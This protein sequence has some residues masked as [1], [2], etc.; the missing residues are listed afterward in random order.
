MRVRVEFRILFEIFQFLCRIYQVFNANFIVS[1]YRV[2]VSVVNAKSRLI[3]VE[4]SNLELHVASV[5]LHSVLFRTRCCSTVLFRQI[6]GSHGV[7]FLQVTALHVAECKAKRKEFRECPGLD[8]N[9]ACHAST[10]KAS[11]FRLVCF[12][13]SSA[14][15]L[16]ANHKCFCASFFGI[17]FL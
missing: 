7:N 15:G 17:Y 5:L 10:Y 3:L 4:R 12:F 11:R 2:L 16:C 6:V 8:Y 14:M 13:S 1:T 9:I